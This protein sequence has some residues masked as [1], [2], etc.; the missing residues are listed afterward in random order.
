MRETGVE[1]ARVSPLD[2]ES[3][4]SANSATLAS[5]PTPIVWGIFPTPSS[6]SF[7]AMFAMPSDD[8]RSPWPA[9]ARLPRIDC[10]AADHP[11][12]VSHA[13]P[14]G[15]STR[16]QQPTA[17]PLKEPLAP[18]KLPVDPAYDTFRFF[19]HKEPQTWQHFPI[20]ARWR[21]KAPPRKTRWP[22]AITT[23]MNWSK[24]SR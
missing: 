4:A 21:S 20:S 18:A 8:L 13:L 3:S 23:K 9:L 7:R 5:C 6:A 14:T 1:P 17:R 15:K 2:P 22:S 19:G 10:R 11:L 16:V 12:A 24:A